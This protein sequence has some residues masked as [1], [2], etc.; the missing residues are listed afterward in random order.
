[1]PQWRRD[2]KELF[3]LAAGN[4][5]SVEVKPGAKFEAGVPNPLFNS[6]LATGHGQ[7]AGRDYEVSADGKRILVN[8]PKE[9]VT[10]PITVVLNW[11]A[12]LKKQ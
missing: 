5:T 7:A 9:D 1:M 2:G 6:G 10:A 3:Y 12:G 8:R 11:T 4:L